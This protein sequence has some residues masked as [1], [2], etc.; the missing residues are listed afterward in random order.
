MAKDYIA[1]VTGLPIGD[2]DVRVTVAR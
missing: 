1:G 2:I